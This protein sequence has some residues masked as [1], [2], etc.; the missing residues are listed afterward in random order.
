MRYLTE[1]CILCQASASILSSKINCFTINELKNITINLKKKENIK[2]IMSKKKYAAFK[3]VINV[4][5]LKRID[6]ITLPFN[7]LLKALKI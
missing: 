1:S 6:C 4:N 5:N 2:M 3:D 7:A